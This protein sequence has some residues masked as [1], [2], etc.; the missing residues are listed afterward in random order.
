MFFADNVTRNKRRQTSQTK[1][2]T[3]T[4]MVS[5]AHRG[6]QWGAQVILIVRDIVPQLL[7]NLNVEL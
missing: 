5:I 7:W 2:E 3:I 1:H 6:V 4:A